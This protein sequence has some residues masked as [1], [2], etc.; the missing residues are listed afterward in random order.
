MSP[1]ELI[2]FGGLWTI[3]CVLCALVLLLYRQVE[4]AYRHQG[5]TQAGGLLPGVEA[6]DIEILTSNGNEPLR[7]PQ[8]HRLALL[9]F[10]TTQCDA[11]S[12]FLPVLADDS[13]TDAE[14]IV[15]M[16]G[17]RAADVVIPESPRVDVLWL[18]H[19]PDAVHRYGASVAPFVYVLRGRTVLASKTISSREALAQLLDEA[20]ENERRLQPSSAAPVAEAPV[21]T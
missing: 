6:P 5:Q 7:L 9:A 10:M 8:D 19:P 11:C 13:A 14:V 1:L 15:L 17:G 21:A 18:A 2:A 3:A 4:K 16:S 12:K 20:A